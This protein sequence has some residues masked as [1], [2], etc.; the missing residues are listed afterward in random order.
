M[1]NYLA[2]QKRTKLRNAALA[3][4]RFLVSFKR[5]LGVSIFV[6]GLVPPCRS[7]SAGSQS[8]L[9]WLLPLLASLL[10]ELHGRSYRICLCPVTCIWHSPSFASVCLPRSWPLFCVWRVICSL[11]QILSPSCGGS[12]SSISHQLA[13]VIAPVSVHMCYLCS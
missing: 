5:A 3:G 8:Y 7:A 2:G 11:V 9:V 1:H 13:A 6:L 4:G 12:T 10:F